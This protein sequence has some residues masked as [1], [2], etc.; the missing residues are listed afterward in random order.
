MQDRVF[1]IFKNEL[2]IPENTDRLK[3]I[4]NEYPGWDSVAHMMIVAAL[5][6][7]FDCMMDMQDILDMSSFGT[8]VEIMGKY[9]E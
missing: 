3:I 6:A 9:R 1:A 7:E 8:A 4:Y 5:E 2:S